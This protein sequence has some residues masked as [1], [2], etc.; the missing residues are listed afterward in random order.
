MK[1]VVSSLVRSLRRFSAAADDKIVVDR[2]APCIRKRFKDYPYPSE[3]N[4]SPESQKW[5]AATFWAIAMVGTLAV[6]LQFTKKH[7]ERPEFIPYPHLRIR[8][9]PFPWGDGNHTL[10]HNKYYNAL[11][12]GYEED[13]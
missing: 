8:N 4:M 2:A 9:K 3:D 10:F 7:E 5:K 11:P 12:D 6:Y 13:E 1:L